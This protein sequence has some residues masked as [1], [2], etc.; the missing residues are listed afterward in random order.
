MTVSMQRTLVVL[1]LPTNVPALLRV[2]QSIVQSMT[3]N[4][5]FPS[6]TPPLAAVAAALADLE[7]AEVAR[8]SNARGTAAVRHVK[9][10]ALSSLL[11]RLKAY[12][13]GVADD[14][15]D[16]AGGI[17]ESAGMSIKASTAAAKPPFAARPLALA[18]SVRLMVRAVAREAHYQWAWSSDGGATW[19]LAPATRGA[20]K[21]LTGLPS[22]TTCMFRYRVTTRAGERDWSEAVSLRVP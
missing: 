19:Q 20:K 16:H 7:V 21:V 14:D 15:P 3:G 5:Y 6:P 18:G 17:I 9:R 12:V 11:M 2:A 4:A 22:G 1:K 8:L 13:Q 10:A